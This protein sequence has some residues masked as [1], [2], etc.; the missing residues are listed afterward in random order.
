MGGGGADG[1][2]VF[3][4][5]GSKAAG[6]EALLNLSGLLAVAC[7]ALPLGGE[8]CPVALDFPNN[9]DVFFAADV[10]GADDD[11]SGDVF[12]LTPIDAA[13]KAPGSEIGDPADGDAFSLASAWVY[14]DL[15]PDVDD[16]LS[17]LC[18]GK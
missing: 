17:C 4:S 6:S 5:A 2:I 1:R 12:P 11:D 7:E 15:V 18:R 13:V 3:A 10:V 9:K 16:G 14:V 8:V